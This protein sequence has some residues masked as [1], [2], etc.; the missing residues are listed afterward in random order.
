[1]RIYTIT[2]AARRLGIC[3]RTIHLYVREGLLQP[4][5]ESGRFV[6]TEKDMEEL[7]RIVRLRQDLAVNTAGI[8]VIIEMRR[9]ILSLQ[10]QI[11]HLTEGIEKELRA[12][13][14][15]YLAESN[16]LP[17]RP[18]RK[19]ITKITVQEESD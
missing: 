16:K 12:R 19:D 14:K 7:A 6:F 18:F 5:K 13:I 17:A 8:E 4:G 15:D 10:K 3:T 9:K 1:M 2:A 11:D